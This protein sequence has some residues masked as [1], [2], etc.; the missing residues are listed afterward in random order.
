[1]G[2]YDSVRVSCPKCGQDQ[3][4]QS[5]SG[6]CD[7]D[8]F[9]SLAETPVDV[10]ADVNRHA[11]FECTKCGTYFEVDLKVEAKTVECENKPRKDHIGVSK[12]E[13]LVCG[14][15]KEGLSTEEMAKKLE[16]ELEKEDTGV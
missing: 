16:E 12:I 14:Y 4:A 15:L 2:L 7:L 13:R 5:K 1:M 3:Y 6:P 11:P 9:E 8:I 10:L